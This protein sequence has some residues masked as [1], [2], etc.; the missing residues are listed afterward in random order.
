MISFKTAITFFV[1]VYVI[2]VGRT[3]AALTGCS[4]DKQRCFNSCMERH[5]G[6]SLSYVTRNLCKGRCLLSEC[7]FYPRKEKKSLHPS[8]NLQGFAI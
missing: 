3:E 1:S 5:R 8:D 6:G 7:V 4:A 2:L